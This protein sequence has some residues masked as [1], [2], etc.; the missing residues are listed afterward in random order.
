M[1]EA[2]SEIVELLEPQL[3]SQP[4]VEEA[5]KAF[6]GVLQACE[7]RRQQRNK[8]LQVGI[9]VPR[10]LPLQCVAVQTQKLAVDQQRNHP[11]MVKACCTVLRKCDVGSC[12]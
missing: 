7:A 6:N 9:A 5:F 1:L 8:R 4:Q 11:A 2:L 12:A 10:G 3:L